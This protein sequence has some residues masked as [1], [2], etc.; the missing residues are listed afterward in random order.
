MKNSDCCFCGLRY[1]FSLC[2]GL[3]WKGTLSKNFVLNGPQE[4]MLN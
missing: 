4:N 2:H 1:S 3:I